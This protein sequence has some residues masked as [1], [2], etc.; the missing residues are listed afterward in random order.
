M[1]TIYSRVISKTGVPF[2]KIDTIKGNR[3]AW[4]KMM[5]NIPFNTQ[6]EIMDSFYYQA[7]R[8]NPKTGQWIYVRYGAVCGWAL[9]RYFN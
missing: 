7:G 4:G 8:S 3:V 5:G 2:R 1:K 9:G 6:C